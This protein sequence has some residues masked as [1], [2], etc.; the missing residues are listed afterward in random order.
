[1]LF[2]GGSAAER[3]QP[4]ADVVGDASSNPFYEMGGGSAQ[5]N[6]M[7][8]DAQ[9]AQANSTALRTMDVGAVILNDL[10]TQREQLVHARS[11]LDGARD[12]LG[13]GQQLIRTMLAR[14]KFNRAVKKAV[15][16]LLVTA[17]IVI[18]IAR[19]A[20][21]IADPPPPPPPPQ[22]LTFS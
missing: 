14:A 12:A 6:P 13:R 19:F 10:N 20:P 17:I 16:C 11:T 5:A 3:S 8:A 1:M 9:L 15:L 4:L 21:R 18:L 2:G 22:P 7:T